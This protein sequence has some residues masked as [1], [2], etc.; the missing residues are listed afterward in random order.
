MLGR[1]EQ[2]PPQRRKTG[3]LENRLQPQPESQLMAADGKPVGH[4]RRR[5]HQLPVSGCCKNV[6]LR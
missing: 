5:L 2:K 6:L 3:S 1:L 4:P